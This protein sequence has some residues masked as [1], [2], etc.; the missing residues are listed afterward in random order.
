MRRYQSLWEKIK[1]KES[2]KI[3][4]TSSSP[5]VKTLIKAVRKEKDNDLA[6]GLLHTKNLFVKVEGDVISFSLKNAH[7]EMEDLI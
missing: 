4:M 1:E 7:I 5:P 6:Y 2:L 3:R